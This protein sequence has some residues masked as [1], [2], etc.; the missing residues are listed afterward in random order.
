MRH[1]KLARKIFT[2]VSFITDASMTPGMHPPAQ[3]FDL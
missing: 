1:N 2:F 3:D